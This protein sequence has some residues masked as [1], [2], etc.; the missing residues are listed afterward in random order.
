MAIPPYA[1]QAILQ[2]GQS[3]GGGGT[4]W[5]A[6]PSLMQGIFGHSNSPYDKAGKTYKEYLD[7]STNAFNTFRDILDREKDPSAFVNKLMGDYQES[8]WAKNLQT[9]ARRAAINAGSASG[10]TGSTP[11]MNQISQNASNISSEDQ[12]NWLK[13][14][15]GVNSEYLSGSSH[16]ADELSKLFGGAGEYLGGTA[17]G[18]ENAKNSDR[19]DLW[20]GIAKL[21]GG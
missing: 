3:G 16:I 14:V 12:Q 6:F 21:F 9:N 15:L 20:S 8:P 4:F 5:N 17:Y 10:L 2:Q 7:K 11:L 1:M 19:S 18:S 13:N